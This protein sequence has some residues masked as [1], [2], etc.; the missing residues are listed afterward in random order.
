M[1]RD[2]FKRQQEA[3]EQELRDGTISEEFVKDNAL[4]SQVGGSHYKDMKIQPIVFCQENKLGAC[5]SS[6]IKYVCR[7]RSKNGLEDL[8]K[9]RHFI[10]ILIS[11]EYTE[12]KEVGCIFDIGQD[13]EFQTM[14]ENEKQ[15]EK[16]IDLRIGADDE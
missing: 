14:H 12:T 9:A 7:H 10:D 13:R 11:L 6:I 1:Y 5:E 4:K 3:E 16:C 8:R 2:K 15:T